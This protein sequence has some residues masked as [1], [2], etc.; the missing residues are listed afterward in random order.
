MNLSSSSVR[1]D[2]AREAPALLGNLRVRCEDVWEGGCRRWVQAPDFSH[3]RPDHGV[4]RPGLVPLSA[5]CPP[6]V[7]SW[8]AQHVSS[9]VRSMVAADPSCPRALLRQL[10]HDEVDTVRH[11][12]ASHPNCPLEVL[13]QLADDPYW[14]VPLALMANPRTPPDV[15]SRVVQASLGN[16][17]MESVSQRRAAA[18]NP[19]CPPQVLRQLSDCAD[20]HVRI[21]VARHPQCPPDV[22]LH[23]MLDEHPQV[24]RAALENPNL[25]EEYRVL[26]PV[27]HVGDSI[28]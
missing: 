18:G 6:E 13:E 26:G 1:P 21:R 17:A 28:P 7:L 4:V 23:M 2:P 19:V 16:Y 22:L 27:A 9:G 10:A 12:V 8:L 14:R 5:G 3:R 24:R 11:G 20:R 15:I 25:P